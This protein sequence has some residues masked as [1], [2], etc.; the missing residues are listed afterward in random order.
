MGSISE[1]LDRPVIT[2]GEQGMTISL[3]SKQLNALVIQVLQPDFDLKTLS[4][5]VQNMQ[6]A[7]DKKPPAQSWGA[8]V[9]AA[10][11]QASLIDMQ[12]P[13]SGMGSVLPIGMAEPGLDQSLN[14]HYKTEYEFLKNLTE[15]SA[16]DKAI[17]KENPDVIMEMACGE[18]PPGAE[19]LSAKIAEMKEMKKIAELQDTHHPENRDVIEAIKSACK[20]FEQ[21]GVTM[22]S[23]TPEDNALNLQSPSTPVT[24]AALAAHQAQDHMPE[25]GHDHDHKHNGDGEHNS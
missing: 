20:C 10:D 25:H 6:M 17:L 3:S 16:P 23:C 8:P 2:G 1:T 13:A 21:A 11:N 4:Y 19:E 7:I 15:L 9:Q 5:I 22:C 24:A 12:S 18:L 14:L